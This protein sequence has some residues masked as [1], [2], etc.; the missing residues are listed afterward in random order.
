MSTAGGPPRRSATLSASAK[1]ASSPP[2]ANLGERAE[3]G[4]SKRGDL[5]ADAFEPLAD[6]SR[7]RR[8]V[9]VTRKRAAAV[10]AAQLAQDDGLGRFAALARAAESAEAA[11]AKYLRGRGDIGSACAID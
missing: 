7:P 4:A 10:S 6:A 8:G 11:I 9:S 1:R 2:E 3:G 5:E